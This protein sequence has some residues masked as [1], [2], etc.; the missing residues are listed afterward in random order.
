MVESRS[1]VSCADRPTGR[2]LAAH[3]RD[4]DSRQKASSWRTLC[5]RKSRS[6]KPDRRRCPRQVE[7]LRQRPTPQQRGVM[8]AVPPGSIDPI[9]V[10]ALMRLFRHADRA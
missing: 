9:T 4:N 1:I 8:D 6:Q 5:H 10:I 7:Q 3:C 2:A